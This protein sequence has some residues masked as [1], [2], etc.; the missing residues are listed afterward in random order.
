MPT[1]IIEPRTNASTCCGQC[2]SA[3]LMPPPVRGC[4][5][6]VLETV[7]NNDFSSEVFIGGAGAGS[8]VLLISATSGGDINWTPDQVNIISNDAFAFLYLY[9]FTDTGVGLTTRIDRT[10]VNYLSFDLN[11]INVRNGKRLFLTLV[12]VDENYEDAHYVQ[13]DLSSEPYG[14]YTMDIAPGDWIPGIPPGGTGLTGCGQA[15]C[16][17][18][19]FFATTGNAGSGRDDDYYIDNVS[20]THNDCV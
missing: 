4:T 8:W 17:P 16:E 1:R 9:Y 19:V 10:V 20:L 5:P 15:G 6:V 7:G 2:H 3:Q 13:I 18:V 11:S 14:T 12:A